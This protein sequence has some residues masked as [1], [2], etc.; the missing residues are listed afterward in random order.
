MQTPLPTESRHA[1]ADTEPRR[2]YA[3]PLGIMVTLFFVWGF[4]TVLNDLLIPHLKALFRLSNLQ[5][6]LVQFCFFGA[7][8]LMSLPAGAIIGR[9][10]Y[11][12]S[13]T[14]AL[15][16]LGVGL[17]MFVPA[18]S[19]V[20]YP[21]FLSGL[22]VA[23]CGI[24][25]L[26]VA[27]NPYITALGPAETAASRMN[28]AGA[29]NS[30]ATTIGP[31]IGA[32][33]I[34]VPAG[35]SIAAQAAAVR[36]PYVVIAGICWC[37]AIMIALSRL[38]ELPGISRQERRSEVRAWHFANLRLG[39]LAI[40]TYVGAEVTIGS[41]LIN[42]LEQGDVGG[43]DRVAAARYLSF[44]WGGALVGRTVGIFALQRIRPAPALLFAALSAIGLVGVGM[45]A[46][47]M[48]AGWAVVAVGLFNSIMWPCIFPLALRGLG[49]LTSEGSGVLVMMVVGG[50]LV[51]LLQGYLAD[52]VG[53]RLSFVAPLACY[54]CIAYF[55]VTLLASSRH[56]AVAEDHG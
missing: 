46:P 56:R 16:T 6:M 35:A 45:S 2:S 1:G 10:G 42:F 33:V 3:F 23:A 34:F 40:F 54:C 44:Y 39:A 47:G 41:I 8:F 13:M 25:V 28:L 50:A 48:A 11:R 15:A 30:L 55:A 32:A 9:L 4:I 18:A 51:P 52:V 38:P 20:S 27:A 29:M 22:F 5:A 14:A 19:V 12:R 7:Y 53:Y 31:R 36:A 24:T 49:P 43:M 37:L 21:I 17:L 26:Q